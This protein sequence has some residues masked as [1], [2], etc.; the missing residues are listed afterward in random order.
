MTERQKFQVIQKYEDF[1]L[2]RYEACVIAEVEMNSDFGS[3]TNGAFRYL[4]NYI[5]KGNQKR[6]GIS[7]TA[8]VIA[9]TTETMDSDNWRVSFVMPHGSKLEHL[10]LPEDARV[11]LVAMPP[12]ECVALPFKGKANMKLAEQKERELRDSAMAAGL[13]LSSETRVSRFDP[14]FTSARCLSGHS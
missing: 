4:F 11:K 9:T 10:P 8:P 12:Q 6:Q 7:M 13:M 14:P 1:E 3:A 2:R 5:S